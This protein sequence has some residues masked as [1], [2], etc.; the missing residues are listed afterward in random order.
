MEGSLIIP[1][2]LPELSP[3]NIHRVFYKSI[4]GYKDGGPMKYPV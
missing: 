4:V 3:R 1:N 2:P